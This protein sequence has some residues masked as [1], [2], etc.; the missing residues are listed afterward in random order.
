MEPLPLSFDQI[1]TLVKQLPESEKLKLSH[2]LEKDTLDHK[3]TELLEAFKTDELPQ[4]VINE[5]RT[6]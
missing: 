5:K 4:E 3:L 1:L 6:L 2:E